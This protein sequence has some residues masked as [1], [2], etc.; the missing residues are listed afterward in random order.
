MRDGK[1]AK[2]RGRSIH[3][4]LP[5]S[6]RAA[7]ALRIVAAGSALLL[8]PKIHSARAATITWTGLGGDSN[9]NT[10][11]N[12]S[13][14]VGLTNGNTPSF[15]GSTQLNNNN[16]ISSS[17]YPS[18]VFTPSAG[19][20]VLGGNSVVLSASSALS[21]VNNS[22]ATETI[23]L[24]L[25]VIGSRSIDAVAGPIVIGGG[26]SNSATGSPA[27]M[28][29]GAVPSSLAASQVS[30]SVV[31]LNSSATYTTTS[32]GTADTTVESGALQIGAGGSLPT[33]NGS[34]ATGWVALGS[35]GN[36]TA[37]IPATAGTLILGDATTPVNVTI[38]RLVVTASAAAG[39]AVVGGNSFI[40]TLNINFNVA[41]TGGESYSGNLGGTGVNQNNLALTI[42]GL[43]STSVNNTVT[44]SGTNTY[45][46]NT[47]IGSGVLALS[48]T[49]SI[50]KSPVIDVGLTPGSAA[51]F[52]VSVV[53]GGFALASG[54]TLEGSGTVIGGVNVA[55]G[56]TLSPGNSPGTLSDS[57]AVT[58]SGGGN[59]LWQMN[60][61]DG[62]AGADPGWDLESITGGLNITA[63]SA[64]KFNIDIASLTAGDVAGAAVNFDPTQSY[65]WTI[66]S[67]GGGITGFDPSAFNLDT[68]NFANPFSG[69]FG[70]TTSGNNLQLTY[71]GAPVP[72]PT[73]ILGAVA[74]GMLGLLAR[75]RRTC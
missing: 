7:K 70:I 14:T 63:T 2:A 1:N 71:T 36:A 53:S 62:T 65:A 60:R 66:A 42:N 18:I 27:G 32:T 13:G 50:V 59:Y 43:S 4:Q 75:R 22:T 34:N 45:I 21:V 31:I 41:T 64:S 12:W 58:F 61:A 16:N 10:I 44:L 67:A 51:G 20:F 19:A 5:G 40:S 39:S 28:F 54:Q 46:G 17:T 8:I 25:N 69:T 26:L 30:T 57:G 47:T 35:A 38:N 49:G 9:W 73:G 48:A 15:A 37:S 72:E 68:S 24:P 23:D 55:S 11:Q 74:A 3:G 33:G 29:F 6:K 52:N 56:S